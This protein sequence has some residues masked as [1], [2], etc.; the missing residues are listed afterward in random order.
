MAKYRFRK[1]YVI[2]EN[3]E[4]FGNVLTARVYRDKEYALTVCTNLQHRAIE[5]STMEHNKNKPIPISKVHG[6]YLVHESLFD[7]ILK[8]H[9]K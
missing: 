8:K 5:E 3:N 6:F 1:C 2:C 4:I 7:D 9:S